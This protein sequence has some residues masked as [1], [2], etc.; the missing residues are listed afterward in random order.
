MQ[1]IVHF[2]YTVHVQCMYTYRN[3]D[4]LDI[5]TI[6]YV[7]YVCIDCL[8]YNTVSCYLKGFAYIYISFV[9]SCASDCKL[10]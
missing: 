2:I 5:A 8:P 4:V 6:Q 3:M 1:Y 7:K 10:F 9:G